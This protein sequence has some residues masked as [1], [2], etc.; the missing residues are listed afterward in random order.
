MRSG[1]ERRGKATDAAMPELRYVLTQHHLSCL[2][3]TRSSRRTAEVV[4]EDNRAALRR[5]MKGVE[6]KEWPGQLPT[7]PSLE[8]MRAQHVA[9]EE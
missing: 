5:K 7:L 8:T 4:T 9:E 2:R 3:R 6:N 1:S